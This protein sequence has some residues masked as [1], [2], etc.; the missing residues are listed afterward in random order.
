MKNKKLSVLLLASG[1]VFSSCILSPTVAGF[2]ST[3]KES[4]K[5]NITKQAKVNNSKQTAYHSN[6]QE[7]M[8]K[9]MLSSDHQKSVRAE[10]IR[11]HGGDRH[12]TCVYF[13]SEELRRAGVDIPKSTANT[14]TLKSELS[15]RGWVRDNNIKNLKPGDLVF[16]TVGGVTTHVYMFMGWADSAHTIVYKVDNQS[17]TYG[18]REVNGRLV[19]GDRDKTIDKS[20]Y[21]YKYVGLNRSKSST[22][23]TTN[24]VSTAK[25]ISKGTV[26]NISS[27]LNVRGSASTKGSVL[28]SL[29]K[30][31]KVDITGKTGSWYKI[32]YKGKTGYVSKDYIS[33]ANTKAKSNTSKSSTKTKSNTST[34]KKSTKTVKKSKNKGK[35]NARSGLNMRVSNNTKSKVIKVI[36]HNA[37]VSI[38]GNSSGW[39]KVN[40]NGSTGWVSSQYVKR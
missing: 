35:I 4:T 32:N 9:Y 6:L 21:F 12:N 13:A 39:Y 1:M 40:Y 36:P 23:N 22:K 34:N 29:H 30:G 17:P 19:V 11:L 28:G 20:S 37:T 8:Y 26:V 27:S 14:T 31:N 24:N 38:I 10:C 2:A 5:I 15:K 18:P 25:V 16:A 3:K 7:K 33:V